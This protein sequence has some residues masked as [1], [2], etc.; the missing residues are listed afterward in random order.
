MRDDVPTVGCMAAPRVALAALG[1]GPVVDD[2][3]SVHD[4]PGPRRPVLASATVPEVVVRVLGP[5][6]VLGAARPFSRAW[7]LELVVYLAM[8][9]R[10]VTADAWT[11]ALWPDRLLADA[12]RHSTVSA[13][14]RALGRRASGGD[15]LPRC[16]GTARLA[17]S[18]T[19][20]WDRFQAL[21]VGPDPAPDAWRAALALVRGRPFDGLRAADWTVLEGVAA[22]VEDAIV[23]LAIRCSEHCLA[24]GDGRGAE[25][26]IR[27]GLIA[28]PYDERL[29]RQLMVAADLQ[30]NPA[31][32]EA[33]MGEL[34][35]VTAPDGSVAGGSGAVHDDAM[36]WV[37][38]DTAALYCSL[39]R[40]R[41]AVRGLPGTFRAGAW[42]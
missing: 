27:R 34:L 37:H 21:A 26:A 3:A 28:S 8:H 14:R 38:P 42:E 31:G 40:R 23:Q 39:S 11:T 30:G 17:T 6:D 15:H 2:T 32:V 36:A 16:G 9:P 12:T 7:T 4:E 25:L 1:S 5:V 29:Y 35:R 33:A 24:L 20:D 22:R 19:T 13:A 18:V 41:A 10:G